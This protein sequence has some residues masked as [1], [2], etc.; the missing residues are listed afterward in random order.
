MESSDKSFEAKILIT[1]PNINVFRLVSNE[2][3]KLV[4]GNLNVGMLEENNAY[5]FTLGTFNYSILAGTKILISEFETQRIFL[6][7]HQ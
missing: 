1:L 6:Y 4:E 2:R 5:F 3:F 7:P